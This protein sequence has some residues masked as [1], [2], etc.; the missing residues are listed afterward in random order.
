MTTLPGSLKSHV[1]FDEVYFFSMVQKQTK[2]QTGIQKIELN[3]LAF[4]AMVI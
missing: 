3:F 1:R 4:S 2:K